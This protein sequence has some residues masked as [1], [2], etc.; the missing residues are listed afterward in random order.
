MII[1]KHE[2]KKMASHG[3]IHLY[4]C[5]HCNKEISGPHAKVVS[6][7]AVC[8]SDTAPLI[9][10]NSGQYWMDCSGIEGDNATD[11][12]IRRLEAKNR[13]L[14]CCGNCE[15]WLLETGS[16][17]YFQCN[18]SGDPVD[19][20]F[21]NPLHRCDSWRVNQRLRIFYPPR[22]VKKDNHDNT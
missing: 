14:E 18:L 1:R 8:L 9:K 16:D 12:E 11:R 6:R 7:D 5:I 19:N 3:V 22:R 21:Q 17:H 2:Y 10:F 13:R 15:H 20:A 4:R